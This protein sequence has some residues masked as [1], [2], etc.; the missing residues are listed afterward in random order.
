MLFRHLVIA[1]ALALAL[2]PSAFASHVLSTAQKEV[3]SAWLKKHP[4]YRLANDQDCA[5]DDDLRTIRAKGYGGKWKPVPDY[6]PY[7]VSGDFNG[8]GEI[9][10]AVAVI[11][12][13]AAHKFTIVVFNG[14]IKSINEAPS[15]IDADSN[16]TGIGFFYGPPRPKPYRLAVG[17]FESE[18]YILVPKGR[19]Y[20]LEP[21]S[22]E[23]E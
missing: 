21:V 16:L 19:S 1:P 12:T 15:F 10:F 5:C 20:R 9:D 6:H 3:V 23:D 8:D 14:P 4:G 7:V 13:N 2:I 18:G 17:A 22:S 11:R